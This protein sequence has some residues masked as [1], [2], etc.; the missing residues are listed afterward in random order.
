MG[1]LLLTTHK[2]QRPTWVFFHA[3]EYLILVR[4]KAPFQYVMQK[5]FKGCTNKRDFQTELEKCAA[6]QS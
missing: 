6:I 2:E 4:H 1:H 3:I 5:D